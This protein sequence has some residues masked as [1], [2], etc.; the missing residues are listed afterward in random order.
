MSYWS[1]S[2]IARRGKR[3]TWDA[4]SLEKNEIR[5]KRIAEMEAHQ[6]E[7]KQR[8]EERKRK[9]QL[10]KEQEG[11]KDEKLSGD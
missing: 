2:G 11:A 10:S 8:C 3:E 9:E 1:H 5:K 4:I 7:L 6:E